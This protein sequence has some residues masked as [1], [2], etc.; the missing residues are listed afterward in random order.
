MASEKQEWPTDPEWR[1]FAA[2]IADGVTVHLSTGGRIGVGSPHCRC[3]LGTLTPDWNYPSSR[4]IS[5]RTG[6]NR[7]YAASFI[8]G[9]DGT[10][11]GSH[12]PS[13]LLGREYRKRFMPS[14]RKETT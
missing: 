6:F 5:D 13:K 8:E 11:R 10:A 4:I 1:K 14:T 2:R 9:F 7:D 12:M 3:P